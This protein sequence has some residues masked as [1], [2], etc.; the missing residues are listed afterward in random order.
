MPFVGAD[1]VKQQQHS[2][3]RRREKHFASYY[4]GVFD[5]D[6]PKSDKESRDKPD[7]SI[8]PSPPEL[9]RQKDDQNADCQVEAFDRPL[10]RAEKGINQGVSCRC[11]RGPQR[12]WLVGAPTIHAVLYPVESERVIV[13]GIRQWNDGH[14]RCPN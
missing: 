2:Q 3:K 4:G 9:D 11:A 1:L 8:E 5:E 13:V 10:P 6:R 7:C 14:K 12:A